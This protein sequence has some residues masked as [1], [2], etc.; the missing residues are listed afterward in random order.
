M[1]TWKR[2]TKLPGKIPGWAAGLFTGL[3]FLCI[4]AYREEFTVIFRKAAMIC[5]ECIGIG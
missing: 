1:H 4:G 2:K 3:L 5:L